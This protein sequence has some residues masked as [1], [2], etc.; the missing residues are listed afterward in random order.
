MAGAATAPSVPTV[1]V[2]LQVPLASVADV[3][4]VEGPSMIKSE[5]G[6]L[7]A[8]VQLSVRNR[9]ELGFVA[10]AKRVVDQKVKIPQGMHIEWSGQFE[11]QLRARQTL[12]IVF[13]AVIAVIVLEFPPA[14]AAFSARTR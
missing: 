1:A 6:R 5:N 4:V 10:E 7:R 9:D 3:R 8:Y 12:R 11:N 2:P 14:P 13:P